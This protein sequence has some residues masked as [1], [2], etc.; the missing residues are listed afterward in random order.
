MIVES[1]GSR[2]PRSIR[3][4]SVTCAPERLLTCVWESPRSARAAA[5][6]RAPTATPV[7]VTVSRRVVALHG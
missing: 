4:T 6:L 2:K 7:V 3:E 1:R 5:T